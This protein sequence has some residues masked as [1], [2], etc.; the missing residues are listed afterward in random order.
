MLFMQFWS[1][2]ALRYDVNY[3][4]CCILGAMEKLTESASLMTKHIIIL[5]LIQIQY[6]DS[7]SNHSVPG[8]SEN[9][10]TMAPM[11]A[12]FE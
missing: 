7:T 9:R 12:G 4:N 2:L 3:F 11:A 1:S 6:P 5:A 10:V 8:K